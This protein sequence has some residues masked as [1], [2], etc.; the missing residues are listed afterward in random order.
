[1]SGAVG[2][3]IWSVMLLLA[4]LLVAAVALFLAARV[5]LWV[6]TDRTDDSEML[7][8]F[9]ELYRRGELTEEE[10]RRVQ[11]RLNKR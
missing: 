10:F 2:S 4:L 11:Q 9:R 1:M 8:Q 5:R 7:E 6:E 3:L